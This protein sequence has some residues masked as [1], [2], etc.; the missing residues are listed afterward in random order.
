MHFRPSDLKNN[1]ARFHSRFSRRR[2][3]HDIFGDRPRAFHWLS[4]FCHVGADPT[5]PRFAEA[6]KI[7]ADFF[8]CLDRQ[9]VTGG[10]IFETVEENSDDFAL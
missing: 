7:V 10:I 3:F 2:V 9:R 4:R 1:V 6:H 5:M 8:R